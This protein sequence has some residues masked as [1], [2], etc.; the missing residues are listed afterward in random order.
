M[1]VGNL[2]VQIHRMRYPGVADN[3][4]EDFDLRVPAGQIVAFVGPS[5]A[6]KTTL[7]RAI[8][9]LEL[10][11][12]G[13]VR[14]DDGLITSP[15]RKI[16][17]VYQDNRLLPWMTVAKN[18][19]FAARKRNRDTDERITQL[20]A[21]VRLSSHRNSLPKTLSGGEEGRVVFARVFVDPPKVLL[22]DEPF[23][24]V[25]IALRA[26]L[27]QELLHLITLNPMTV[28]LVSHSV[29]DV[30]LLSDVV[31]TLAANPLRMT[32]R[33]TI[34]VPRPRVAADEKLVALTS[35]II[36]HVIRGESRS[37]I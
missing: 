31:Y 33:F 35:T 26:E 1:M 10:R 24:N 29:E 7:L 32:G 25:D 12:D 5:G 6:G 19:A 4:I 2:T 9:G 17:I 15:N 36:G 30:V 20:L 3:L 11:Y 28:V 21:T 23:R 22:L 16:Q 8:A 18:L 13:S 14:L 37:G 27:Q 34:E